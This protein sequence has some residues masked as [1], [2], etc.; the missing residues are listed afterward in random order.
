MLSL[1][2]IAKIVYALWMLGA[3]G[4]LVYYYFSG[5]GRWSRQPYVDLGI[6]VVD[7][8]VPFDDYREHAGLFWLLSHHKIRPP[9]AQPEHGEPWDLARDYIGYRP[10][11]REHPQRLARV[12]LTHTSLLYIA[13]TYGVYRED[14]EHV[15]SRTAHMDYTPLVFGGLS[16]GDVRAATDFTARGGLLLAEFN[17]FCDPTGDADR[18]QLERVFGV[19]WTGWVGR[20]FADPYDT[21][22]VPRWLSRE[23]A[24][25]YPGRELPHA[26]I[27]LLIARDGRLEVLSGPSLADV[28]PRVLLTKEGARRFP[29]A[30]GDAP[31][32]FWFGIVRAQPDSVVHA[33]VQF[34]ELTGIDAV[35]ERIGAGR[36]PAALTEHAYEAGRAIYFVGDFAD[37]DFDPGPHDD[38]DALSNGARQPIAG[39]G[40]STAPVFWRFY[41]PVMDRLL[42]QAIAQPTPS[43]R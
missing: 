31:Y 18:S 27:L 10:T 26:P 21:G 41:A 11:D 39:R 4:F 22:D 13:D 5:A 33:T 20:V 38:S 1:K 17:S 30:P 16:D 40:I 37:L 19:Q 35:L 7:Y 25:Q 28:A 3:A 6:Q 23:Y 42:S 32:Y 15:S 43:R 12:D 8:T 34:P 14:L 36:E 29:G 9:H 2:R 24:K